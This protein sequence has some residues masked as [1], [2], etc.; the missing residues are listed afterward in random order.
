[1]ASFRNE[2]A[3][4]KSWYNETMID[5]Y[6][7]RV[8]T[9]LNKNNMFYSAVSAGARIDTSGLAR[10]MVDTLTDV[11]FKRGFEVKNYGFNTYQEEVKDAVVEMLKTGEGILKANINLGELVITVKDPEQVELLF[12]SKGGIE[13][14]IFIT[15]LDRAFRLQEHYGNGYIRALLFKDDKRVDLT[16]HRET[17]S[18]P[19][20][21]DFSNIY[22][23]KLAWI[24]K[25]RKNPIHK[26]RGQSIY[27]HKIDTFD[28]LDETLSQLGD[29]IR[30][31]RTIT[32]IPPSMLA[33]DT[34]T[35]RIRKPDAFIG[36]FIIGS[37]TGG[38]DSNAKA[39]VEKADIKADQYINT[40]EALTSKALEGILSPATLGLELG[41]NNSAETVQE[42]EKITDGTRSNIINAITPTLE[43]FYQVIE[44]ILTY[45]IDEA[46]LS[47]LS[48]YSTSEYIVL[49]GENPALNQD[50][51]VFIPE[52]FDD[53]TI[54][55]IDVLSKAYALGGISAEM[56]CELLYGDRFTKEEIQAEVLRL[57]Q[58]KAEQF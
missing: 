41:K 36:N 16:S 30:K 50:I 37:G 58:A 12:D 53:K 52:Y 17:A 40:Y 15:Y 22:Q 56:Y 45:F 2:V 31:S 44:L 10:E 1:M 4:C 6:K 27:K 43:E 26:G 48:E 11:I 49:E 51:E 55:D 57:Q 8:E 9:A 28:I 47:P 25:A 18:L 3:E 38:T 42:K 32:Y 14:I 7:G 33:R 5:F 24:L 34:E 23:G 35:G 13:E 20:N 46:G 54:K 19:D 21:Y 29:S 39:Q